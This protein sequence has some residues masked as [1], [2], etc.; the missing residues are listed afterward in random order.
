VWTVTEATR[1]THPRAR[2]TLASL[3]LRSVTT[4]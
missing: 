1:P 4:T 3:S 2:A